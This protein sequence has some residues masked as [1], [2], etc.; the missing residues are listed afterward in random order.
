[1]IT[2]KKLESVT[3]L[4]SDFS[5]VNPFQTPWYFDTF[6]KHFCDTSSPILLGIYTD[7][8][9][10]GYGAFEKVENKILFL[11]MKPVVNNQEITDYGDIFLNDAGKTHHKEVWNTLRKWFL[12]NGYDHLQL[13]YIREDSQTYELFK[14]Y[15]VEQLKAPYIFL[16]KHWDDYLMV[17]D[18]VDRKELK[19]KMK[20]LETVSHT[21]ANIN[22]PAQKDFEEFIRLHKLSS[23]Q[24]QDFMTDQMKHFFWSLVTAEKKDWK[25]NLCFL[26]IEEKNTSAILSFEN[27]SSVLVYNSGYDPSFNYYSVGL[28]LHAFKIQEA[29]TKG[30]TTYDFMRGTERYKY[31]LGGKDMRLYRIEISL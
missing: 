17:L 24:K 30:K 7:E 28:L 10:I 26:Q 5:S 31:D 8:R 1:M 6:I 23:H 9:S 27:G 19:R 18:R 29:I 25:T 16:P 13:D 4:V 15:A 21:Y 12:D 22:N 20:R 2:I 3:E 14:E 11:G